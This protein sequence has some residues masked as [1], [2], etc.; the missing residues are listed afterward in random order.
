MQPN[1]SARVNPVRLYTA[2]DRDQ[3]LAFLSQVDDQFLPPLSSPLRQGS[4]AA[5]LNYSLADGHGR[6]LLYPHG[7]AF[8]GYLA[9]RYER[10]D[11]QA[12]GETVYLSNMAVTESRMGLVLTR[13]FQ[14]LVCQVAQDGYGPP[15]RIW[16]K[17]WRQNRASARAL[18]RMGLALV[19]TVQADPA[20]HGIRDTLI[21]EGSWDT[22]VRTTQQLGVY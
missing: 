14:G 9:F 3:T 21:L 4:L 15:T 1:D 8:I 13:L 6:I 17:T 19:Q 5:Y 12:L 10:R 18:G 22:F 11:H 7:T 2:A 16:A 20:F